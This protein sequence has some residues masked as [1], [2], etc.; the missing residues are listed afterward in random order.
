MK[1]S[2]NL[3]STWR[4]ESL[5]W[6]SLHWNIQN[7]SRFSC[8]ILWKTS[9]CVVE[10]A[11]KKTASEKK[12][13]LK[14]KNCWR[15]KTNLQTN[16][17]CGQWKLQHFPLRCR[18]EFPP[19]AIYDE[20]MKWM[21]FNRFVRYVPDMW[22]IYENLVIRQINRARF[23]DEVECF[24]TI[25]IYEMKEKISGILLALQYVKP[26]FLLFVHMISTNPSVMFRKRLYPYKMWR[27]FYWNIKV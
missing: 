23:C 24:Y 6:F 15:K 4:I 14:M 18:G 13:Q 2:S 20:T 11:K 5:W 16:G 17:D 9:I 22:H 12:W 10:I 7:T 21:S 25:T 1:N 8:N 26:L 3:W 27:Y 19:G